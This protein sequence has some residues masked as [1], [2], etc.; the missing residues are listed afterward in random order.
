MFQASLSSKTFFDGLFWLSFLKVV[1]GFAVSSLD[2]KTMDWAKD[3]L[4]VV[5]AFQAI[6]LASWVV[7]LLKE[8]NKKKKKED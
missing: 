8:E 7:M 3:L 2:Y 1:A 5:L 6:A 4:I